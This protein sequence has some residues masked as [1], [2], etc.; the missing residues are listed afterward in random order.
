MV[1]CLKRASVLF[2]EVYPDGLTMGVFSVYMPKAKK[3]VSQKTVQGSQQSTVPATKV[4]V[5]RLTMMN[6]G[7]TNL[8]M[9]PVL[10]HHATAH[11]NNN[12]SSQTDQQHWEYEPDEEWWGEEF[13]KDTSCEKLDNN[14]CLYGYVPDVGYNPHSMEEDDTYPEELT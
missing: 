5:D 4:A 10:C 1:S 9:A 14:H 3:K 13:I 6:Q 8:R 7:L 2:D 12:T 11:A